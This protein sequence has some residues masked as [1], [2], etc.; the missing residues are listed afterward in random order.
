MV[1]TDVGDDHVKVHFRLEVDE[2]GWPPA[3]GDTKA[4]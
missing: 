4:P 2:Y 1:V 3:A